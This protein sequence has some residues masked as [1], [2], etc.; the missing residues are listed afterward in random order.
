MSTTGHGEAISKVCLA[1]RIITDIQSGTSPQLATERA[2]SYMSDRVQGTGGAISLSRTGEVG[3][4]FTSMRMAWAWAKG[5][6]LH[7]G[8]E[9][10]ERLQQTV[11]S[12]KQGQPA[13]SENV[14]M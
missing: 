9:P 5:E 13:G 7:H 1:H 3:L 14:G 12:H 10:G 11:E 8:L 4:S 2:L 6:E